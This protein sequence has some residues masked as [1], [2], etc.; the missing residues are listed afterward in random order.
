MSHI[1]RV[2]LL[3]PGDTRPPDMLADKVRI[4]IVA[5]LGLCYIAAVLEQQGIEVKILDCVAEG[6]QAGVRSPWSNETRYGME[7]YEIKRAINDYRPDIVGV[8][9]L[10]SNK[11]WDAHNVC[12]LVKDIDRRIITVMGGAHPTALTGETLK[13][14]NVDMVCVG[15]GDHAL[16][17]WIHRT[18][19][20]EIVR[21]ISGRTP[22]IDHL[23][24]PARHLLNMPKYL[25]SES[26]HSG[27]KRLPVANISTSRG[28]PSA[29]E[30]CAIRCLFGPQFRKRSAD[31]VLKEIQ[32]L[33]DTYHVKE[34]HFEDDCLTADRTRAMAI[35]QGI[36]DRKLDLSLNSPS[37]LAVFAMDEA[38]LDKMKEAGY[39]SVS[40]AIESG[41][42]W[43]LRDLMHKHVDLGKAK[44]L[45][46]YARSIGLKVK[47]FWIVG[48]P[49]ETLDMM[50]TTVD[51]AY[52]MGADWN[53][54]FPATNLPG[55]ELDKRVRANGWL[56]DPNMDPRYL[57]FRPNIRT[58]E[59]GPD[60]VLRIKEDANRML[61]FEQ[62]VNIREGK[63]E[64]AREDIGEVVRLYSQLSFAV[65]ALNKATIHERN[66]YA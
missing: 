42:P 11:S 48:Y 53:L 12:R 6:Q 59:F 28:C 54:F 31:N 49:G 44:R 41:V 52:D 18:N 37:G 4:G 26:P 62:N 25:Y 24:L 30:F 19:T 5:P 7:D 20:T 45:V 8:S 61:N 3:S 65:E 23:P 50:K 34:I 64:R 63:M 47:C 22:D 57:F 9:C 10:F 29:C 36:I 15:D 43:V 27:L 2:M 56:V 35:F 51:I 14:G 21:I 16:A 66:Q 60:D 58:P 33:V 13:D 17:N 39:Y 46:K 55:T 1:K 32:H 40:L 38:L